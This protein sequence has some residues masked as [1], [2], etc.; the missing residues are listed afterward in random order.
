M[1][2]DTFSSISF[3]VNSV[4]R[5]VIP[6]VFGFVVWSVA[7]SILVYIWLAQKCFESG[8]VFRSQFDEGYGCLDGSFC[9]LACVISCELPQVETLNYGGIEVSADELEQL[10]LED[11]I[12]ELN[13]D[14]NLEPLPYVDLGEWW[15]SRSGKKY[16]RKSDLKKSYKKSVSA[17]LAMA[18]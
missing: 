18:S 5:F 6:R 12:G 10:K 8:Q 7:V 1:S 11:T 15:M 4:A 14:E 3:R 9:P 2:Y 16:S 13:L 17:Y